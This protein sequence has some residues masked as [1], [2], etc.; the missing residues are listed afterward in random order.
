MDRGEGINPVEM[1]TISKLNEVMNLSKDPDNYG[2][3][4]KAVSN[5]SR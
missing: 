3:E 2:K 5:N 4:K 1:H